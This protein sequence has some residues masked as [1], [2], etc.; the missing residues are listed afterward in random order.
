MILSRRIVLL[1][2]LTLAGTCSLVA[3]SSI[4]EGPL[5]Q[6]LHKK[7][8]YTEVIDS[9]LISQDRKTLVVIGATYHYL[10]KIPEALEK[11]LE[12]PYHP[13]SRASFFGFNVSRSGDIGGTVYLTVLN[14]GINVDY[15]PLRQLERVIDPGH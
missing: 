2:G 6:E 15:G 8:R 13:H 4:T 12:A 10:F 5:T 1:S 3:C 14:D 9:I 11:V 7:S